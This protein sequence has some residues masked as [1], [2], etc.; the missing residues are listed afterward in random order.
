MATLVQHVGSPWTPKRDPLRE[1]FRALETYT[2]DPTFEA[3]G[4]FISETKPEIVAIL[5][6]DKSAGLDE[7]RT[8]HVWG[9]FYDFSCVFSIYTDDDELIAKITSAVRT[10]KST[11]AYKEARDERKQ[12]K[13]DQL[14]RE[15]ELRSRLAPIDHR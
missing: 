5:N 8:V 7:R 1:L 3:Y 4:D 6:D 10:N 12:Q 15:R 2:L 13:A 11:V 14:K 9:N